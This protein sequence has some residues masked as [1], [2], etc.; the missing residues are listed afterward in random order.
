MKPISVYRIGLFIGLLIISLLVLSACSDE[1]EKVMSV[2]DGSKTYYVIFEEKPGITG[3]D[4][5]SK[6]FK[7][8]KVASQ[9]LG[10]DNLVVVKISIEGDKHELIKSNTLFYVEEGT[11]TYD[12]IGDTGDVLPEGSKI[13]GFPS[14]NALYWFKTKTKIGE[15]SKEAADKA[16]EL[17]EK[18]TKK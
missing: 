12:T 4:V 6:G 17:Y 3:E 13:L 10:S 7:I 2:L 16:N 14:K 15:W 9:D 5:V 11:L 8:G 18:A 1:K